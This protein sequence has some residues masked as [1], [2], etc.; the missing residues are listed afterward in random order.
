MTVSQVAIVTADA[1]SYGVG[2]LWIALVTEAAVL[3]TTTMTRA[4]A[5]SGDAG[6]CP[7]TAEAAI[8]ALGFACLTDSCPSLCEQ[9][10]CRGLRGGDHHRHAAPGGGVERVCRTAFCEAGRRATCL[11]SRAV[12][13]D[14]RQSRRVRTAGG[15]GPFEARRRLLAPSGRTPGLAERATATLDHQRGCSRSVAQPLARQ[16][17]RASAAVVAEAAVGRRRRGGRVRNRVV[18]VCNLQRRRLAP[19]QRCARA[20]LHSYPVCG[21][22]RRVETV[23]VSPQ[24]E[25]GPRSGLR[26]LHYRRAQRRPRDLAEAARRL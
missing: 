19:H 6:A 25:T 5:R 11:P 13:V 10:H 24:S 7:V 16:P 12:P 23:G 26:L 9:A 21:G 3:R 4:C 22:V 8:S 15:E 18:T 14:Q 17:G 20:L 1:L 2:F